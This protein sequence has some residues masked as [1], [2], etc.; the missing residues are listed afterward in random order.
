MDVSTPVNKKVYKQNDYI[1]DESSSSSFYSSFLYKSSESSCN[2]D[3]KPTEY[4][5][6]VNNIFFYLLFD[7]YLII[8]LHFIGNIE[9][10]FQEKKIN[11]FINIYL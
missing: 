6:E 1:V 9:N 10:V 3:Q 2:P 5:L 11:S 4:L 7:S 8:N